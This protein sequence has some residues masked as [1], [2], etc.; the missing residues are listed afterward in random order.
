M[1]R[2]SAHRAVAVSVRD[3][4]SVRAGCRGAHSRVHWQAFPLRFDSWV[5]GHGSQGFTKMLSNCDNMIDIQ[6]FES[7]VMA[8]GSFPIRRVKPLMGTLEPLVRARFSVPI[9]TAPYLRTL[10]PLPSHCYIHFYHQNLHHSLRD[11]GPG[12]VFFL[13]RSS[14]GCLPRSLER[15]WAFP[16]SFHRVRDRR[17]MLPIS[18]LRFWISEGSTQAEP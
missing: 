1:F 3:R 5:Y 12:L 7:V 15:A 17:D 8:P 9:H 4:G 18:V 2:T 14:L 10:E 16:P 6:P 13:P 11:P